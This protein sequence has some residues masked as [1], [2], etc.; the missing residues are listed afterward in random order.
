MDERLFFSATARN[1]EPI[2]K[3]LSAFLPTNGTVLEIASG[4]GEH[5]VAFQKHFKNI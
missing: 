5:A 3:V 1:R 2:E 4:S